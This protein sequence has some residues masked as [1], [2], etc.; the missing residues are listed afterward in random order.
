M[1][2]LG[3][4]NRSRPF[5]S[6][7]VLLVAVLVPTLAS[8]VPALAR[9]KITAC[10]FG[11]GTLNQ[12]YCVIRNSGSHKVRMSGWQLVDATKAGLAPNVFKFPRFALGPGK[13]VRVHTGKGTNSKTDLYRGLNH[14]IMGS[15]DTETLKNKSGHVVG[16]CSWTTADMSPKFC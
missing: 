14:N 1:R 5:I 12:E 16:T 15:H 9:V 11:S 10:Y 2:A 7:A 6:G 3:R 4:T 8:A 13:S